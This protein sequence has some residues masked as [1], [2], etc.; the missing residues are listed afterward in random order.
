MRDSAG[1]RNRFYHF[2]T[3]NQQYCIPRDVERDV[4]IMPPMTPL[5]YPRRYFE[6]HPRAVNGGVTVFI[7]YNVVDI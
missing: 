6:D 2:S 7:I 4:T 1:E 3:V 5:F